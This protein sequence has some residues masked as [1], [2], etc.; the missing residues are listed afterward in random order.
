MA[1][2]T[3]GVTASLPLQNGG[4]GGQSLL[5]THWVP[6]CDTQAPLTQDA[7]APQLDIAGDPSASQNCAPFVADVA[8]PQTRD[9][10]ETAPPSLTQSTSLVQ[11]VFDAQAVA[12]Q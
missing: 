6:S 1:Q 2:V 12:T 11:S 7:A 4:G 9:C 10:D 8:A 5:R 3:V